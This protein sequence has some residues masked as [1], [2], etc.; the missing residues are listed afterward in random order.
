M[1]RVDTEERKNRYN[2]IL[3]EMKKAFTEDKKKFDGS[4]SA[5]SSKSARAVRARVAKS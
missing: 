1:E 3:E 4:A 5:S 2:E